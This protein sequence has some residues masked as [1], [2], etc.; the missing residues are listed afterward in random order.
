MTKKHQPYHGNR[1]IEEVIHHQQVRNVV[2]AIKQTNLINLLKMPDDNQRDYSIP[3][4]YELFDDATNKFMKFF[5]E[6]IRKVNR[7]E[8]SAKKFINKVGK[9]NFELFSQTANA[10][11]TQTPECDYKISR[12]TGE[13]TESGQ[14]PNNAQYSEAANELIDNMTKHAHIVNP[15][16]KKSKIVDKTVTGTVTIFH[17]FAIAELFKKR[18]QTNFHHHS[19]D[20]N[21]NTR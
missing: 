10:C 20:K 16:S 21:A 15:S 4:N 3:K 12:I 2:S 5:H 7:G 18:F 6:D 17:I 1:A 13:S 14:F 9:S 19:T 8:L 11:I